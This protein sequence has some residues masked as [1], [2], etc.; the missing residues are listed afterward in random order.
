MTRLGLFA[1]LGMRHDMALE[2]VATLDI[3]GVVTVCSAFL[4]ISGRRRRARAGPVHQAGLTAGPSQYIW[5]CMVRW[6]VGAQTFICVSPPFYQLTKLPSLDFTHINRSTV[7]LG[8]TLVKQKWI[9]KVPPT[10]LW[11]WRVNWYKTKEKRKLT[12]LLYPNPSSIILERKR[13]AK[14]KPRYLLKDFMCS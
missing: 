4:L 8:N 1:E 10:H 3:L 14:E 12:H 13:T 5:W 9:N 11:K 6:G 7:R 2:V